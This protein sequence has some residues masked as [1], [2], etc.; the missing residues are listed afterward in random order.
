M[1]IMLSIVSCDQV[2][3]GM[4]TRGVMRKVNKRLE[5]DKRAKSGQEC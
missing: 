2:G 4:K 1:Q 3:R 5:Y